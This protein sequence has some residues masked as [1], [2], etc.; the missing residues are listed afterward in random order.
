[1]ALSLPNNP[2]LERFRRDARRLQ[3]LVR[4]GDD[5]A[6]GL[7]TAHHPEGWPADLGQFQL[8]DAQLVVAR[9]YGF[10][11]WPKLREY[12]DIAEPLRRDPTLD[13]VGDDPAAQFCALGSLQYSEN[14]DPDRWELARQVLANHPDLL[15]RSIFAAATAGDPTAIADHLRR[16]HSLARREG[17]PFRW[18]ALMYLAYSRVGQTDP[19]AAATLLLDQ[20]ADPDAGYLWLAL[21]TPFTVLTG[22]FGEGEQGPGRQPRHPHGQAL[23]RLLL[24]RGAEANDGQALYNRMFGRDDDHLELLFEFGLG[25]G[26]GGV[27]KRRLGDAAETPAD[28]MRRQLDWAASQ[29]FRDRLALLAAHGFTTD[30]TVVGMDEPRRGH[31]A[32]HHFAWFG[33]VEMVTRLLAAGA[34]P[35]QLDD[36]HHTTPLVWAEH[37]RQ[38]ATA[39]LLRPVTGGGERRT[40]S[41]QATAARASGR[42]NAPAY[43]AFPTMAPST[44]S[45]ASAARSTRSCRLDTPPEATTG[46]FVTVQT[47]CSSSM[48][49][50]R[51]VPS[52]VTSV[53]T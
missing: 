33:D 34:D 17:G 3:R 51:R 30:A 5:R 47:C 13:H 14:D 15:S 19:V 8:A 32:L 7:V 45:G 25:T 2:D 20:G 40:P 41:P 16:D 36:T 28:M 46:A 26:D 12:L 11:S 21:P 42:V 37:G 23:A 43:K 6:L 50:P 52:L 35:N 48:F 49:G 10:A 18:T 39:A 31:S 53:T 4:A 1:M 9:R 44:P 29:G 38:P 24:D 27:W 22:C